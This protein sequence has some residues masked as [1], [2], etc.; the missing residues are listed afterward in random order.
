M[1]TELDGLYGAKA[2]IARMRLSR[3]SNGAISELFF[4][5]EH[6]VYVD[7]A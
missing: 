3:G 5:P 2:M 7:R 4:Y 1:A 6:F